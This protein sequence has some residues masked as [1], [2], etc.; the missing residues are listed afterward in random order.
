MIDAVGVLPHADEA[1]LRIPEG[2]DRAGVRGQL[3]EHR[4]ARID[5]DARAQIERLLR[6]GRDDHLV[7]RSP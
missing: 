3:D 6:S 7:G 1:G 5:E 4:V 2:R